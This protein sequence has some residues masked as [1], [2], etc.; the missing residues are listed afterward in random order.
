MFIIHLEG[1]FI[2]ILFLI[3]KYRMSN[4]ECQFEVSNERQMLVRD[5]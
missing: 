3:V 1:F 4:V 5:I 2:R